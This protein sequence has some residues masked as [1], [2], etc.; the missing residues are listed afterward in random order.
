METQLHTNSQ[1]LPFAAVLRQDNFIAGQWLSEGT[2][3]FTEVKDKFS[4][5]LIAK[6]PHA[7]AEQV[8][9]AIASSV[10]AFEDFGTWSAEKRRDHLNRLLQLLDAHTDE[11]VQLIVAEAGKP[12]SYAK[13]EVAR[14]KMTIQ[15]AVDLTLHFA[16]EEVNVDY[17]AGVGRMAFTHRFPVGPVSCISPFNF[18]LNLAL[19]KIAPALAVGCTVV[20]KPSPFAPL[21]CLA[22]AALCE[23]AGYPAGVISIFLADIAEAEPIV[24]DDR[25]KM[26]SFTGSPQVG[27][28]LKSIAGKK[29]VTLELGGNAAVIVDETADIDSIAKTIAIGAFLYSGQICISTQRIFVHE[30]VWDRFIPQLVKEVEALG[31]GDPRRED[32]LVGPMIDQIHL[33]RIENWVGSA[34]EN[35]ATVLAGGTVLSREHQL[36]A[37]TLLT[38]VGATEKVVCEEAFGPIA[39]VE[40]VKS[41][42]EAL[43]RT[44]NSV[45]GLQAGVFTQRLDRMKQAFRTLEVGGVIMNNVPGFRVD[46]MPYGGVKDSGL[47]REGM[48][49]AMEDMTEIRLLVI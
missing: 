1:T 11:F 24:K 35:G 8:E 39:V 26:L 37:A 20:L 49:Y 48:K 4:G 13:A 29:K 6:V 38:N 28:Y 36:F 34:V 44:N 33:E 43:K 23:K 25:L 22:F 18:P 41:F 5:E 7:T 17:N 31:V 45:F 9:K 3:A 27:W 32:V 21:S 10:S 30:A 47:G 2:G 19:H 42:D 14:C 40:M 16:G 15:C 46:G 12:L